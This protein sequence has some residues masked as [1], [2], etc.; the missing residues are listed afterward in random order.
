VRFT[1][2]VQAPVT[3]RAW[4]WEQHTGRDKG[5]SLQVCLRA[6]RIQDRI[7]QED[8]VRDNAPINVAEAASS[9]ISFRGSVGFPV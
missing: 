1:I 5:A 3:D 9:T 7:L 2:L 6:H 8:A 4:A